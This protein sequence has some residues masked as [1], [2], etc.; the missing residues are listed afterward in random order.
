MLGDRRKFPIV[1]LVPEFER[2]R[3][4]ATGE[5]SRIPRTPPDQASE[6][7]AKMEAEARKHLRDLAQF[8]VPKKFV[9]LA[10]DFTI[11]RG[12]LTRDV[13]APKGGRAELPRSDAGG[14]IAIRESRTVGR[15]AATS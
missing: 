9:L 6:V 8:E 11:E 4:W 5:G 10:S 7:Q 13:G 15:S 1:L 2:L 3:T 12:E 14:P